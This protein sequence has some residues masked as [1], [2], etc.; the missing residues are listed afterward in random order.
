MM[1]L[2]EVEY[3]ATEFDIG[4]RRHRAL[5]E[6][7]FA[8]EAGRI[9]GILGI[10]KSL[11][12]RSIMRMVPEPG[13]IAGGAI[14]LN[15]RDLAQLS[16]REMR[17]VRGREIA[18]VFQDPQAALNPVKTVGWQI[19]EALIVHGARASDAR[20]RAAELLR[21][22][23][24]PD[25][26]RRVDEFPHQFSGGMRQ[27]VVIAIAMANEAPLI[28]A[29]EPTT[30]LDVTIQAQVLRLLVDLRD[31]LGVSVILITHDMGVMAELCDDVIVMYGRRV[32]E[33]GGVADIFADPKHPYTRDPLRPMPRIEG[34]VRD[35]LPAIPGATPD[36]SALPSGCA[37][38]PRCRLAEPGLSRGGPAAER[39][40]ERPQSEA[41]CHVALREGRLPP[42]PEAA[43]GAARCVRAAGRT[44]ADGPRLAESGPPVDRRT[45]SRRTAA[46]RRQRVG[47]LYGPAE[48]GRHARNSRYPANG[49]G[50]HLVGVR[51]VELE[52]VAGTAE[53]D[54]CRRHRSR[55]IPTCRPASA[56]GSASDRPRRSG[57]RRDPP[58][59]SAR[60]AARRS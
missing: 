37:F 32:V 7:S 58:R 49:R 18:M 52:V 38:H 23:G 27:R 3:L 46:I 56:S 2:L 30:A 43:E 24:I 4:G 28:I 31:R 39:V 35:R 59:G 21:L 44:G 48:P 1:A 10:G 36:L 50:L 47:G 8:V 60:P 29:D 40:P 45:K 22:V 9:L 20:A 19:E 17:Q 34:G 15:G 26:E 13:R 42:Q 6:V 33:R 55:P 5:H 14:R 53:Q 57:R 41:A 12:A 51:A 25:P 54:R 16:E 11:T